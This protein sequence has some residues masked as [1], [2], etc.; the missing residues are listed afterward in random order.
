MAT[1]TTPTLSTVD[2]LLD[3]IDEW[4]RRVRKVREKL[5]H[6]RAWSDGYLDLLPDLDVE[7]D[8]LKIK[9]EHAH[10][11]LEEFEESLPEGD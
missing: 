4:Y 2:R 7:L 5:R 10:Q 9:V 1:Q 3:E 8:V 6:H 11:A